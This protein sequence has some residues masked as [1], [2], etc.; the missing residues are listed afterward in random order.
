MLI[1]Y[2]AGDPTSDEGNAKG[3]AAP[4]GHRKKDFPSSRKT[5]DP[6]NIKPLDGSLQT[7]I[8][9]SPSPIKIALAD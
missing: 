1:P 8:N 2:W 4:T 9:Q 3:K 5:T 6:L 7:I